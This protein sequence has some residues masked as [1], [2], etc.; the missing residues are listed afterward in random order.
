MYELNYEL[1]WTIE[2]TTAKHLREENNQFS[3]IYL[4]SSTYNLRKIN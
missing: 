3:F 4:N 1:N 2:K